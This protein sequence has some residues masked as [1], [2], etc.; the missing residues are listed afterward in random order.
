[1]T[2]HDNSITPLT[3]A[4]TGLLNMNDVPINPSSVPKLDC[5]EQLVFFFVPHKGV[6]ETIVLT[7]L[8]GDENILDPTVGLK[9]FP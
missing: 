9:S 8:V 4:K 7:L 1:M 2:I 3:P 5:S 6:G